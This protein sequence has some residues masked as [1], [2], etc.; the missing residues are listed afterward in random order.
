MKQD[1]LNEVDRVFATVPPLDREVGGC[2]RCHAE[3][4]LRMLGGDPAV[5]SDELVESFMGE[6]V[7]HWDEDQYPLLWRRLMPRVLRYLA[8][9]APAGD[10][11]R[12]LRG[13]ASYGAGF[14]DWPA[15]ERTATERAFAAL[16][17]VALTDG[18]PAECV[19]GL[20]EGLA[21]AIGDLRPWLDRLADLPGHE[22]DAGLVRLACHWSINML[23]EEDLFTWWYDG[24]PQVLVDWL[25]TQRD[26]IASFATKH[27]CKTA[28]DTVVA[29][30]RLRAG[31]PSPWFYHGAEDFFMRD[32]DPKVRQSVV[33]AAS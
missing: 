23:W 33:W 12:E 13:L 22:A 17:T 20:V 21:H 26:R 10:P 15:P 30:D 27:R 3:E 31:E 6:V 4:D 1:W 18:R 9:D 11:A 16:L 5:I 7:D 19:A 29:I 32:L 8:S 14:V 28:A 2:T 24:D 25:P